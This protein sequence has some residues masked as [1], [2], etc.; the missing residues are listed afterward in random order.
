MYGS[1][2]V[3]FGSPGGPPGS[4]SVRFGSASPRVMEEIVGQHEAAMLQHEEVVMCMA[5]DVREWQ[6]E[7]RGNAEGR[8]L[9]VQDLLVWVRHLTYQSQKARLLCTSQIDM[10][11]DLYTEIE[12]HQDTLSD[13]PTTLLNEL[14][15]AITAAAYTIEP[16]DSTDTTT[17][18]ARLLE[19]E[20]SEARAELA[21]LRRL[22]S[23]K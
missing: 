8:V 13:T 23:L 9:L 12:S 11:H 21:E 18:K 3:T 15:A 20:L 10:L 1:P 6:G 22:I 7:L 5:K 4:P 16:A 17:H 19:E 2:E 14:K